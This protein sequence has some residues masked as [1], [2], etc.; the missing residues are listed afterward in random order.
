[1]Q[2]YRKV[3]ALVA[4]V[5]LAAM[6]LRAAEPEVLKQIPQNADVVILIPSLSGLD[7]KVSKLA[8]MFGSQ[9]QLLQDPLQSIKLFL[10]LSDGLDD[11]GSAAVVLSNIPLPGG[12]AQPDMLAILPV[13][14]YAKFVGNFGVTAGAGLTAVEWQGTP[15]FIKQAGKSKCDVIVMASHG[16][17]SLQGFLLG[18]ET[19]K[20]LCHTKMPVLVV[21]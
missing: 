19:T 10:N 18:S 17:R 4:A 9:E 15:A 3:W 13:T 16:R 12:A 5:C 7:G 1:M 6:P 14:D 20:V 11:A 21:R 2:A 8:K